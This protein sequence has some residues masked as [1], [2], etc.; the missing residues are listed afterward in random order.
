MQS[1]EASPD[2]DSCG[3]TD[4]IPAVR[5]WG[6]VPKEQAVAVGALAAVSSMV[7]APQQAPARLF[8]SLAALVPDEVLPRASDTAQTLRMRLQRS[9]FLHPIQTMAKGHGRGGRYVELNATTYPQPRRVQ[10]GRPT[11]PERTDAD[12]DR[13][14]QCLCYP[15]YYTKSPLLRMVEVMPPAIDEL[16]KFATQLARPWL[17]APSLEQY[18]NSCELCVYYTA[19]K[20]TI[21]RH[22][23]NFSSQDLTTYLRTQDASVLYTGSEIHSSRT[24][25]CSS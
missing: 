8:N 13:V 14:V 25:T 17:T 21:G 20:S 1:S 10:W 3:P 18:P 2:A 4:S 12:G 23:D 5:I 6:P 11:V 16:I 15:H 24:A 7:L 9:T 19:F 22:R